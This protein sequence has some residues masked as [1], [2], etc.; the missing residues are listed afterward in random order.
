M[1]SSALSSRCAKDKQNYIC[2]IYSSGLEA[3]ALR[4]EASATRNKEKGKFLY[5]C[6]YIYIRHFVV[7]SAPAPCMAN[8]PASE[9]I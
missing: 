6:I 3:I 4:L 8:C 2:L 5:D 1:T 7:Q 9:A